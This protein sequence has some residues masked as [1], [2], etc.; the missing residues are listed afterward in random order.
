MDNYSIT[1]YYDAKRFV[2]N[3]FYFYCHLVTYLILVVV[4]HWINYNS[5][6]SY[7]AYLPTLGWGAGVLAFG[8]KTFGLSRLKWLLIFKKEISKYV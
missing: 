4:F 7:W 1:Q 2:I 3:K 5:G 8:V 6:E